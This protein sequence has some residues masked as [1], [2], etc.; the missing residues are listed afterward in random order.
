MSVDQKLSDLLGSWTGTNRLHVPWMPEK[1]KESEST[2][3]V[4]SKMNGQFLSFEYTWSF[5]GDPQ[6][7]LLVVGCDPKSDAVQA[8]WT[9][10]W[11]SKG[12]LMLCNGKTDQGGISVMGHYAVP[13]NPD[14][15]WR[16][17]IRQNGNGF[18]YAMYN[19]TPDG[20][21]ELAVETDF[22]RA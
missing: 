19:V 5:D 22:K 12:V 6:E 13:D 8:V 20:V 10:S 14:W 3:I 17:E 2:A 11:H 21:E 15:G 1:M 9:D 16:T 4:R 18:L 7:G